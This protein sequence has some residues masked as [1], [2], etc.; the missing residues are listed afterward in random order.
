MVVPKKQSEKFRDVCISKDLKYKYMLFDGEAHGF[1]KASTISTC[2]MEE[3]KF[4]SE[5]LNFIPNDL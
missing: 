2:I 5:V 1:S 4:Y 3:F